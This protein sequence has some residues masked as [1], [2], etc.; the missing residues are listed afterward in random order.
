MICIECRKNA[1][2]KGDTRCHPCGGRYH[3]SDPTCRAPECVAARDDAQQLADGWPPS[4]E[5]QERNPE[6]IEQEMSR[7]NKATR[8]RPGD[9]V[10]I[11][12][13][14]R[15]RDRWYTA[16][17]EECF[18]TQFMARPVDGAP[19]YKREYSAADWTWPRDIEKTHGKNGRPP[20]H[21]IDVR[22]VIERALAD[23]LGTGRSDVAAIADAVAADVVRFLR[24][25][26][27]G[28]LVGDPVPRP[29]LLVDHKLPDR[30][31]GNDVE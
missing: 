17:V 6:G 22:E 30:E 14:D 15:G 12:R 25:A 11:Q 27:R 5:Q 20:I 29:P 23:H 31:S 19:A 16:I 24:N 4:W 18:Q 2:C 7:D 3:C 21:A 13:P 8:P 28:G 9:M 26:G 10:W 1:A